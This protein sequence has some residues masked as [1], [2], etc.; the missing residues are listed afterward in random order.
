MRTKLIVLL[1]L[2]A[3]PALA[4]GGVQLFWSTTGLASTTLLYSTALTNFLP[5]VPAT[6]V[7]TLD[8]G[9]Y[10]LYAWGRFVE[11]SDLPPGGHIIGMDLRWQGDATHAQ[12]VAYRQRVGAVKRWDG[13]VG[14]PL[15]GVMAAVTA[16]GIYFIL[17]PNTNSDL[18]FPE[19]REF[20][21]GAARITGAAG[22]TIGLALDT[23]LADGLGPF[24]WYVLPNGE[25]TDPPLWPANLTF[26]PEPTALIL[27][28][29]LVIVRRR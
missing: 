25:S 28:S 14:I 27:L 18:Y 20:L 13:S 1:G 11:G 4:D 3:P 5:I 21:L 26:T 23:D 24:G 17:P 22:Q 16:A 7:S 2:L 8:P 29:A 10:D 9:T 12:N 6:P 15:D 19:T